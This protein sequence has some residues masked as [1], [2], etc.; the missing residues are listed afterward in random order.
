MD[1][2]RSIFPAASAAALTAVLEMN[3]ND[4]CA[5]TNFLLTTSLEEVEASLNPQPPAPAVPP[6]ATM[7]PLAAGDAEEEDNGDED[8]HLDEDDE[9][10][11][12]EVHVTHGMPPA[13]RLRKVEPTPEADLKEKKCFLAQFDERFFKK[14]HLVLLNLQLSKLQHS[15]VTLWSSEV[16]DQP[17]AER[18]LKSAAGWWVQH[19]PLGELDHVW[20]VLVNAH[21]SAK[22]FGSVVNLR[23]D[24]SLGAGSAHGG[25]L[26][27]RA[28]VKDVDEVSEMKRVGAALL[29]VAPNSTRNDAIFF[30]RGALKAGP[31]ESKARIE[32]RSEW[33]IEKCRAKPD[34]VLGAGV[35]A[36]SRLS[37]K[38][39]KVDQAKPTHWEEVHTPPRM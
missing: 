5:A 29:A 28:L 13:K 38:L 37:Y 22:S 23:A 35:M 39:Y 2:L 10:E 6:A 15:S 4:V 11:D 19:F 31:R 32:E 20:R 34:E 21:I 30:Q 9:D 14:P 1:E 26:E 12:D 36:P 27:V 16:A 8:E 7:P 3:G 25:E 18:M 17:S 24:G 33:K